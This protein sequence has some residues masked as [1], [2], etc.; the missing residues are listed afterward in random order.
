[1]NRRDEAR[2]SCPPDVPPGPAECAGLLR[3]CI[4]M[5]EL[6]I[7]RN[8]LRVRDRDKSVLK[9]GLRKGAPM[10]FEYVKS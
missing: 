8:S 7:V 4:E 9:A 1:M 10:I 6:Q 3:E 5:P 2:E